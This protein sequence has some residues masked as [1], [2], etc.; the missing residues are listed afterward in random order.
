MNIYNYD[1]QGIFINVSTVDLDPLETKKQGKE[2]YLI[3]AMATLIAPPTTVDKE[4]AV[5]WDSKWSIVEDH[6]G[7]IYYN[8]NTGEEVIIKGVGD[9]PQEFSETKP[10]IPLTE[11]EEAEIF[12]MERE[13]KITQ[14]MHRMAEQNLID[15]GEID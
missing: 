3:P 8:K 9:I 2:I 4:V 11:E 1:K 7:G 15:R 10:V 6:R 12:N 13:E 5:F 14:E